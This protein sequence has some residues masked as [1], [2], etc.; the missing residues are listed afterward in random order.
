M[1]KRPWLAVLA[2]PIVLFVASCASAPP[3]ETTTTTTS[4]PDPTAERD[5]ALRAR[6]AASAVE[7][8]VFFPEDWGKA[9]S[10]FDAGEQASGSDNEAAIASFRTAAS[11]FEDLAARAAPLYLDKQRAAADEAK[12]RAEASRKNA[13]DL[14][15][16]DSFPEDWKAVEGGFVSARGD[17]DTGVKGS[18]PE[19]LKR[20]AGSFGVAAD[21]YDELAARASGPFVEKRRVAL[22]K[23]RSDA[24]AAG[25]QD[26]SPDR[27]AVADGVAEL[28]ASAAASGSIDSA[29][30]YYDDAMDRYLALAAASRAAGIQEEID[31]RDLAQYD[32]GNYDTAATK[33]T[34]SVASFDSGA[35]KDARSAAEES[36][37][38]FKLA[39]DKGRELYASGKGKAA[40]SQRE[41]ARKLKAQVAVKADYDAAAATYDA[42]Q[43][44]FKAGDFETAADKYVEAEQLFAAARETAAQK[45]AAAEQ[46]MNKADSKLADS[47]RAA[48]AADVILEGGAQ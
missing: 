2:A 5:A 39:L 13:F 8:D 42:A 22:L 14:E 35:S 41:E 30:Q 46:A 34:Q 3:P 17:Y 37:L 6:D 26:L 40:E 27:L 24:V 23:A 36:Q 16:P 48:A 18:D 7:A 28:A 11:S 9:S 15:A 32:K 10:A 31:R 45:R 38:R 44:A 12:A 1:A 20:S 25:I 21:G 47:E 33:L 29:L 43:T 19:A 4:V